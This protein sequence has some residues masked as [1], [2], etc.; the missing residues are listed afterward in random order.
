MLWERAV[1][2]MILTARSP[3]HFILLFWLIFLILIAGPQALA[4]GSAKPKP[5]PLFAG[6]APVVKLLTSLD[7]SNY[8]IPF[9]R[10]SYYLSIHE[11]LEQIFR[12]KTKNL[13]AIIEVVHF[14]D[15]SDI[16][17]E[18]QDPR[19]IAVFIV[20]HGVMGVVAREFLG[21]EDRAL[22]DYQG[23]EV[24]HALERVHPNLRWLALIGCSSGHALLP[25]ENPEVFEINPDFVLYEFDKKI[26][27]QHGLKKSLRESIPLLN[28]TIREWHAS[29]NLIRKGIP[30]RVTRV[31]PIPAK[32]LIPAIS[33]EWQRK[34]LAVLPQG[35]PGETQELVFELPLEL[36]EEA[37]QKSSWDLVV[38]PGMNGLVDFKKSVEFG[39]ITFSIEGATP[40]NESPSCW[41]PL[42][43]SDGE[44]SG[45]TRRIFEAVYFPSTCQNIP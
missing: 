36:P 6:E 33:I 38:T 15:R 35:K 1:K 30:I 9:F 11:K 24:S 19:N 42:L 2:T 40:V 7:Y 5:E 34:T 27:A 14:A 4:L 23:F 28:E 43:R 26:G 3:K 39:E 22:I 41:K 25:D 16:W 37:E 13:D 10:R 44:I 17:R 29:T 8:E 45:V 20:A 21:W 31:I 32:K 12:R 18:L